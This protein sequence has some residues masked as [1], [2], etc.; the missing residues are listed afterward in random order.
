MTTQYQIIYWRDIPAQVKVRAG[1]TRKGQP[2]PKRFETAIDQA[3]MNSGTTG[4]DDYLAE[5]RTTGWQERD[6]EPEDVLETVVAE[7]DAAYP[8]EKIK[9]LVENEGREK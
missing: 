2:L 8:R 5:W 7:L 1:R 9:T 4:T 3:A 6:G